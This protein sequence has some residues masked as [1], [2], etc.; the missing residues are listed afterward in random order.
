MTTPEDNE[1]KIIMQ[2]VHIEL[3]EAMKNAIRE[4]FGRL[5]RHNPWIIRF[6]IR[7]H[8]DQTVGRD[9]HYTAT[10]QMEIGGPDLV[11]SVEGND[12]YSLFDELE[13]KLDTLLRRRHGIRKDKRNHPHDVELEANLPKVE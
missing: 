6:N 7:L 9:H 1:N 4:K 5:L 11:A 2:G 13:G 10:G 8:Q 3:T 12:P